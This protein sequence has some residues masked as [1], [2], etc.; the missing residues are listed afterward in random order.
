MSRHDSLG[1]LKIASQVS[2][3][4]CSS[5]GGLTVTG[6]AVAVGGGGGAVEALGALL[7]SQ[8]RD[9]RITRGK[10]NGQETL[11]YTHLTL[12]TKTIV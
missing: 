3:L 4:Y 5:L 2:V 1:G 11:S 12:P 8:S 10:T 6:G 9:Q 7:Q